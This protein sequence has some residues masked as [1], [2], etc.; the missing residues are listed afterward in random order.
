MIERVATRLFDGRRSMRSIVKTM[1]IAAGGA[2]GVWVTLR[3]FGRSGS[4][5]AAAHSLEAWEGEGG[6]VL[7]APM[8]LATSAR[9]TP[10]RH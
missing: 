8:T 10:S 7:P 3:A 5:T 9:D 2:L 6:S 1:A 4:S